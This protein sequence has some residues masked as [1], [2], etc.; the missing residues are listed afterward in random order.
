[1]SILDLLESFREED[2][3]LL[4]LDCEGAEGEILEAL[5]DAGCLER[6]RWIRGEWHFPANAERVAAALAATHV[7]HVD[8]GEW[9]QGFFIAHRIAHRRSAAGGR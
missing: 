3:D 7:A 6:V 2:V 4:K 8:V 1:M 5:R 9:P